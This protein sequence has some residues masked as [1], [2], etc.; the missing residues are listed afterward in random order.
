MKDAVNL[1]CQQVHTHPNNISVKQKPA[2]CLLG[3]LVRD[4]FS[5]K[6]QNPK[7]VQMTFLHKNSCADPTPHRKLP[8]I[9]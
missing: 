8:Q 6:V 2:T 7:A 1:S 5:P 9:H 3:L 4:M